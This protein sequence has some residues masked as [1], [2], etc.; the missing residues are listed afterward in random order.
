MRTN[1]EAGIW[2]NM[3]PQQVEEGEETGNARMQRRRSGRLEVRR[4]TLHQAAAWVV[5]VLTEA[6]MPKGL[7]QGPDQCLMSLE[8]VIEESTRSFAVSASVLFRAQ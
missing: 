3:Q 1:M 6:L 4:A 8:S 7:L 2:N 5:M